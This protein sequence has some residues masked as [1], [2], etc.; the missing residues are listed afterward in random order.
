MPRTVDE[1]VSGAA[2]WWKVLELKWRLSGEVQPSLLTQSRQPSQYIHVSVG[3][4]KK[5][6][7]VTKHKLS[8]TLSCTVEVA[9]SRYLG[10]Y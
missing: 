1:P 9:C 4:L 2:H 5:N 7:D 3:H 10:I 6:S 8:H